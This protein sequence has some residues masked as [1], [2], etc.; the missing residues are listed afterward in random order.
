MTSPHMPWISGALNAFAET[1]LAG[2]P[3]ADSAALRDTVEALALRHRV[4]HE[5]ECLNLNPATNL[6]NPRAEAL[7]AAG[8]GN[9]PSLGHPGDKYEMGLEA[10]ERI[11]L[12]ARRLAGEVFRAA[13]A[14]IRVGS[15]ALANLYGFMAVCRPGDRIIV[16]PPA[17]GGHVTHDRA[18]AAGYYGLDIH[19]APVD[20]AHYT[21]DLVRLREQA[22]Q[23]RPALITI[24]GSLNLRPHP[25]RQL[26]QIAD[27]VGAALL[28]DAA[29]QCGLFAG[30][31]WPN[32]LDDGAH[33]LTMSTY[34]SLG[35]PAGGLI[36]S[37][38]AALMQ[39]IDAIAYP[40][41]TANSDAARVAALAIT[42]L[43]WRDVGPA[44]AAA[45]VDTS[46]AL[47][48]AL[49]D[50][51][52]AVFRLADGTAT[53]SHQFALLAAPFGGGQRMARQLRQANILSCGIGLPVDAIA[54]DTNGLR[55]GTPEI[56]R[57]GM[58]PAEMRA[59]AR[60]IAD[61]LWRRRPDAQIA[62]DVSALRRQYPT[63]RFT[64]A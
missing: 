18:G 51:G 59:V 27:D 38:D 14:E 2:L 58:G 43:D 62:A 17:I 60:L 57:S 22:R 36:V 19:Y 49:A 39:R 1:T 37:R 33:L 30:G 29:H 35:G 46:R 10:V 23:I 54:D 48:Q 24:G 45:M 8:L 61:S 34:K 63:V 52:L 3:L 53:E 25:V 40:G 15:G 20:P 55:L 13:Y 7:L 47:A 50:E 56:V 42:L 9:R 11:E 28:V 32:P 31:R 4:V 6:M 12:I 26:R 64:G 21:V 44:Y 5:Q 41:L 16:P